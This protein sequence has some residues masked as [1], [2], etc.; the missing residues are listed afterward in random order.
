[1]DSCL[2]PRDAAAENVDPLRRIHDAGVVPVIVLDDHRAAEP[3]ADAL[4]ETGLHCVEVTLRTDA[5]W[6]A[7]EVLSRRAELLTGAGTVL[8]PEQVDRCVESGAR[9]V[10]SPGFDPAV[11]E[12]CRELGVPALPG[13]A[14]A[15]EVLLARRH[16]SRVVKFF[17]AEPAGGLSTIRA[18]AS[19]IPDVRFMPTGGIGPDNLVRYLSEPSVIA[20][21]G[22]W[23]APRR[24]LA[25]GAWTEIRE[26]CAA[27]ARTVAARSQRQPT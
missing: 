26:R 18:M 23:M 17:P 10:V 4:V 24:L 21:G 1:M 2:V 5:A 8:D 7:L 3:L 19:A 27:A 13:T 9:F 15:T 16:G 11:V 6:S 22:S 20:V 25:A 12:R 14:T